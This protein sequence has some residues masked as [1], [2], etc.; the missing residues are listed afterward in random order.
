M[1]KLLKRQRS[2]VVG[3]RKLSSTC[4]E[5]TFE[6]CGLDFAAGRLLTLHGPE[7]TDDRSYTIASGEHDEHLQ[8]IFRHIP[9]G[10]LTPRLAALKPGDE[11]FF[12][13]PFGEFTVRDP[14]AP[15]VFVAT[16]TG[17][18]PCR[19]YLRTFEGLNLT[20][21]HG[22]RVAE[23]LLYRDIFAKA[24]YFP[25]VTREEGTGFHGRVTEFLKTFELPAGAHY[26]L[27]GA[28]EMIFDT[29]VLLKNRGVDLA[30][31]HTEAYYYR[32]HS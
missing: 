28:N 21:I 9:A 5:L 14:K 24:R 6:R 1:N 22:V 7:S 23:D 18:A 3:L 27:C 13:G 30:N 32:L 31:V 12:S 20:L 4:Y 29:Q 16:G 11:L 26:H 15:L 25:C 19:V 10:R 2:R 8:I 17:V